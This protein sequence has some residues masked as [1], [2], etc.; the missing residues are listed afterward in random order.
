MIGGPLLIAHQ[1]IHRQ[2]PIY[3]EDENLDFGQS[4]PSYK[5]SLELVRAAVR[6]SIVSQNQTL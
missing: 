2:G 3:I 5:K 4:K 1:I 6:E